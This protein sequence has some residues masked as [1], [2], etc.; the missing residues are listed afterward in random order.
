[1]TWLIILLTDLLVHIIILICGIASW[2]Y[3]PKQIN[4]LLGYRTKRSMQNQ[5]TWNFANTYCGQLFVKYGIGMSILM[6][7]VHI[8]LIHCDATNLEYF[9]LICMLI[10][11]IA[12][13]IPI[14]L[15]EKELQ[16]QFDSSGKKISN[17][18]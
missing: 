2:K 12:L 15:T 7:I 17:F 8:P 1:M 11:V 3:P 14:Y 18:K 10:Q 13:F 4:S 16:K 9:S 6:V 5:E